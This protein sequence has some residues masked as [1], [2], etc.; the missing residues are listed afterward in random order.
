M[1]KAGKQQEFHN[2]RYEVYA[3]LISAGTG[4]GKTR[5]GLQ[6]SWLW[7]WECPNSVGLL[8]EPTYGM[9]KR[10]LIPAL[11]EIL[12]C[13]VDNHSALKEYNKSDGKITWINNTVWWLLGLN[14]PERVEGINAD[15]AWMDE[16]RLIGGSGQASK[17]KQEVAWN[18][19]TRRLR[20]STPGQYPTGLWVTTTP[21]EP[22][23][24]LHT[25]FENPSTRIPD[26]KVYRWTIFDNPYLPSQYIDEVKRSHIEG[27]GLY[28]RF[29]LGLFAAVAAG[30]FDFDSSKHVVQQT[31][32]KETYKTVV[33]GI[34]WG[35]SNPS[36]VLAIGLDYDGRAYVLEEF[37][38]NR[39][40]LDR[41]SAVCL[42]FTKK[43]GVETFYCDRAEPRNIE[44]LNDEGVYAV[45]D[46]TKRDDGIRELGSRFSF[47]E[48][49][50][51]R[52]YIHEDCVNLISELQVYDENVKQFDHAVDAV[53]YAL[54]NASDIGGNIQIGF[55]RRR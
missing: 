38:Q 17:R 50:K 51:A 10:I 49:G 15:W 25:K 8:M 32:Q 40:T 34:D 45:A 48:D 1:L 36:C 3:R 7:T 42:E 35:W 39:A 11:E 37:Y 52:L 30:T 47:Q 6:E 54:A 9:L 27:T 28:N 23:S 53:R 12:G 20:G 55:G 4:S 33:G 24:L 13:S 44:H 16:F 26:S 5:A 2:D 31:P 14:E 41:I 29:V 19:I 22:G 21:D 46:K 43:Y 18:T